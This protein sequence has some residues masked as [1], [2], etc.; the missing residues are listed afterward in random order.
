M[1]AIVHDGNLPTVGTAS[2]GKAMRGAALL[3]I[4]AL[5]GYTI[6]AGDNGSAPGASAAATAPA[7]EDWHGNVMRSN[8]SN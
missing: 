7:V 4:G 5:L 1:S 8:W 2:L 3:L 6:G